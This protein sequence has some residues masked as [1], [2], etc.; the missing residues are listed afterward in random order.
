MLPQLGVNPASR[1]AAMESLVERGTWAI[2]DT[3]LHTIDKVMWDGHYYSSKPPL[4]AAIGAPVYAALRDMT[5]LTFRANMYETASWLRLPLAVFPWWLGCLF[6]AALLPRVSQSGLVRGWG[7]AAWTLASL[8]MAYAAD[9][10]NHTWSVTCLVGAA[11]ALAPLA[12]A[13]EKQPVWRTVAGGL[14]AGAAFCFDLGSGPILGLFGLVAAAALWQRRQFGQ[15]GALVVAGLTVPAIQAG[16]QYSIVGDIV[17]FYLKDG[18]YDYPNSYWRRPSGFDAL[19][20]PKPVY[21]FH[22]LIGHHGLFSHSPWLLLGL[23]WLVARG[24]TGSERWLRLA[25]VGS[26]GFLVL[27]YIFKS[28]NYGGLCIGMRW[29]MVATPVLAIAAVVWVDRQRWLQRAPELVVALTTFGAV[30]CMQGTLSVW[31]E[32]LIHVIFRAIGM[33]SIAG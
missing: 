6:F 32:G 24:M 9:L 13:G 11:W 22:A 23:P 33:G 4:M 7:I 25:S 31:A 5:G 28:N 10:N 18:A 30:A 21:A 14:L 8:P 20:E 29:Y 27:Y 19:D 17:P 26:V 16:I 3:S 1:F 15:L 2:D 12:R